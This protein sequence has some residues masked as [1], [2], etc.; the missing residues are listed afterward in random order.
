MVKKCLIFSSVPRF[1]EIPVPRDFF[2]NTFFARLQI[3][4]FFHFLSF[5][6]STGIFQKIFVP[7]NPG[8]GK[9]ENL[10]F[11]RGSN[12]LHIFGSGECLGSRKKHV[13]CPSL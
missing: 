13:F 5:F 4:L 7:E 3:G 11:P 9:S 8:T 1:Y 10:F 2:Q 6:S 12:G